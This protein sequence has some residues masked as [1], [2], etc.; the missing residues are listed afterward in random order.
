MLTVTQI[1]GLLVAERD[2]VSIAQVP[3][4]QRAQL[5]GS[6]EPSDA[7]WASLEERWDNDE[8][9]EN[10][11]YAWVRP[12]LPADVTIDGQPWGW[13]FWEGQCHLLPAGKGDEIA[14][15]R[16]GFEGSMTGVVTWGAVVRRGDCVV[17]VVSDDIN[18]LR[19]D[20]VR[21]D[22]AAWSTDDWDKLLSRMTLAAIRVR[23]GSVCPCC[24]EDEG[25]SFDLNSQIPPFSEAGLASA[26]ANIWAPCGVHESRS[27]VT[28]EHVAGDNWA[29]G[30]KGWHRVRGRNPSGRG[31][32]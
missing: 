12:P 11:D 13:S 19:H 9:N 23:D 24:E 32:T 30:R 3:V 5:L 4:G 31:A 14:E 1:G 7:E 29:W 8:A 16:G 17:A 20:E 2:G 25:W 10:S 22:T 26:I 21:Y 28:L 27:R 6:L 15:V 18:G